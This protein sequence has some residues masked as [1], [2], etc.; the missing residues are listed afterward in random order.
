MGRPS[1][2]LGIW[3][4]MIQAAGGVLPLAQ[5]L[6]VTP[7]ALQWVFTGQRSLRSS[8]A[9]AARAFARLHEIQIRVFH[10]PSSRGALL[11]SSASGWFLVPAEPGGWERATVARRQPT[12]DWSALPALEVDF[13][14]IWPSIS[15]GD[16]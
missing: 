2:A 15:P 7:R 14:S 10:H 6:G 12:E 9:P 1:L 4:A 11:V 16:V 5:R 8:N 3:P 13:A